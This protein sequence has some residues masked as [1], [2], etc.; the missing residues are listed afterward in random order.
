MIIRPLFAV[1][2]VAMLTGCTSTRQFVPLPDQTKSVEDT[3][4]AR[5]Y[6]V[7]PTVAGGAISMKVRDGEQEIGKTG[8]NGYLCWE[9][10]PG[11]TT[12]KSKA[13]NTATLP[14]NTEAG[15]VYYVQQ[16]IRIG[17]LKARNK[18]SL[19]STQEGEEALK[20]CKPPQV[21]K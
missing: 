5:I 2:A 3:S 4:K 16:H 7:R 19:L 14:L 15:A 13:E 12:I 18:L 17:I 20:K 10:T 21:E 9:R 11:E 1:L 6:V 8:A